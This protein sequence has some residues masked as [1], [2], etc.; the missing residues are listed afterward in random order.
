MKEQTWFAG[1]KQDSTL[2]KHNIQSRRIWETSLNQT[3]QYSNLQSGNWTKS[4]KQVQN[5]IIKSNTNLVKQ[6]L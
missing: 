1:Q 3:I 5:Y 2:N 6:K 4:C